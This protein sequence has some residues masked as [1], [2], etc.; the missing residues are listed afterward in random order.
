MALIVRRACV[1]WL[2]ACLFVRGTVP[3]RVSRQTVSERQASGLPV[4][5]AGEEIAFTNH[6]VTMFIGGG[7]ESATRDLGVG[8]LFVTSECAAALRVWD[9]A[10]AAV[11]PMCMCSSVCLCTREHVR[12]CGHCAAW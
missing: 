8:S 3:S 7:G 10:A 6:G 12:V 1:V 9:C 5:A 2:L 11:G 4:L